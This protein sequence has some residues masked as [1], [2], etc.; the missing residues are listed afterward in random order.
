MHYWSGLPPM[1]FGGASLIAGLLTF[2]VPDTADNS[3][4]NTVK[5]AEA[6]GKSEKVR[7]IE[8]E[9]NLGFSKDD[10]GLNLDV[11]RERRV[12]RL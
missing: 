9:V 5:Q 1:I 6:L 11:S 7:A 3:L 8:G 10:T 2:L 12:S 4:P